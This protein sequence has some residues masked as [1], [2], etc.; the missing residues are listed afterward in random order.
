MQ[1]CLKLLNLVTLFM[2]SY[3]HLFY[4]SN[5]VL[6]DVFRINYLIYYSSDNMLSAVSVKASVA[7]ERLCDRFC[8]LA[9]W[10][11]GLFYCFRMLY[12]STK[13]NTINRN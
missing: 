2:P 9:S 12:F 3:R 1:L 6:S 10:F 13:I 4:S 8:V 11:V 5:S 7:Y